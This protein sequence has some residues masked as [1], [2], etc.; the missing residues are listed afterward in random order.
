MSF[1]PT[2][3]LFL[4][5]SSVSMHPNTS[6][7]LLVLK[8]GLSVGRCIKWEKVPLIGSNKLNFDWSCTYNFATESVVRNHDRVMI[9]AY[10][11][12]LEIKINYSAKL[13]ALLLGVEISSIERDF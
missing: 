4:F 6:T 13:H 8:V 7:K 11:T 1:A 3:F 12:L 10:S 5:S 2:L 9:F